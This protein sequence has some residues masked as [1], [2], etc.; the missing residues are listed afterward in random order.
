MKMRKRRYGKSKR[1]FKYSKKARTSKYI[2]V[3]R[4]GRRF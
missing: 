4:G 3:S 1:S 2:T